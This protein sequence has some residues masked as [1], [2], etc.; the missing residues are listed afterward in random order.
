MIYML[1]VL[2]NKIYFKKYILAK[3]LDVLILTLFTKN[4]Y[5]IS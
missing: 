3:L 5:K 4:A 2:E 1:L